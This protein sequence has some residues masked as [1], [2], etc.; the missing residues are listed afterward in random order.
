MP[1]IT[2]LWQVSGKNEAD[3]CRD[4]VPGRGICSPSEPLWLDVGIMLFSTSRALAM[5]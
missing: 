5:D 4:D 3:I 2:G 1:G